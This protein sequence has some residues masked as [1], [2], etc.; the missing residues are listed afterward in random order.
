MA[1]LEVDLKKTVAF[2]T[3]RQIGVVLILRIILGYL[4][5]VHML[6]HAYFKS[7]IF[8]ISGFIF[9][10]CFGRQ[11]KNLF[12]FNLSYKIIFFNLIVSLFIMTGFFFSRSFWTKDLL[13]EYSSR[14]SPVFFFLFFLISRVLTIIYCSK[15]LSTIKSSFNVFKR[16]N[17]FSTPRILNLIGLYF[18][19]TCSFLGVGC[20]LKNIDTLITLGDIFSE[21]YL[22]GIDFFKF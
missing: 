1:N 20:L 15:I 8:V 3:I 12:N 10:G 17:F 19:F 9:L 7:F 13:L 14:Q 5:L 22:I 21:T 11:M 18:I 4:G 2:S 6:F 16:A